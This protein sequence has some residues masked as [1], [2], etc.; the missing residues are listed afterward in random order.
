M[1]DLKIPENGMSNLPPWPSAKN[2]ANAPDPLLV[3][4][5]QNQIIPMD[6]HR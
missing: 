6:R 1:P 2:H 4:T 3:K 5:I